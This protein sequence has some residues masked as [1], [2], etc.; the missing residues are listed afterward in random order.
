MMVLNFIS[1]ILAKVWDFVDNIM[2]EICYDGYEYREKKQEKEDKRIKAKRQTD[3]KSK[4]YSRKATNKQVPKEYLDFFGGNNDI[5]LQYMQS[6][7]VPMPMPNQSRGV[8]HKSLG[9]KRSNPVEDE[10]NFFICPN[11]KLKIPLTEI[12]THQKSCFSHK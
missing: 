1:R 10:E 8:Q 12:E 3:I 6:N 7:I 11:C 9:N 2:I 4:Q 5:A